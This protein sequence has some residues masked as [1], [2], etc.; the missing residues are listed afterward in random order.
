M[1]DQQEFEKAT[2]PICKGEAEIGCVLGNYGQSGWPFS[3]GIQWYEG[4]P[5]LWKNLIPMGEEVGERGILEGP[6]IKG[7]RCRNCKKL[8][9]NY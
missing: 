7:L 8:I 4:E 9:L 5:T 2:C 3:H 6:Y 1:S